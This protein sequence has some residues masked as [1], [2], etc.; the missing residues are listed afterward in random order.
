MRAGDGVERGLPT[1]RA[2]AL[3][4]PPL[5]DQCRRRLDLADE[6]LGGVEMNAR[7]TT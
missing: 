3:F 2:L 7:R 1:E 4:A 6:L 5:V